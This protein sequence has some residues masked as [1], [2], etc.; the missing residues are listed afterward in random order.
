MDLL[1]ILLSVAVFIFTVAFVEVIYLAW[2]E[3]RFTEKRTVKKRLLYISAGGK[4]GKEKLAKYRASVLKDIGAYERFVLSLPRW[5]RLDS[6]L[7]KMGLPINAS[8]FLI[9]SIALGLTGFLV[10]YRYLPQPL[11]AVILGVALGFL[12]YFLLKVAEKNYY[13]KFIDQLPEALD[14]L[15]RAMRSGHALTSGLEMISK[16]LPDPIKSE[17]MATVDE[18]NLGLTLKEAMENLCE[19]VPLTDLRYF[20][21]AVLVQKETGGNVAEILDNISRLIRERVQFQRQVKA[22][23]AEGRYSAAVLI[24]L[25]ILMFIYIYFTNYDYLSLLWTEELG[26]YLLFGAIILQIVGAYMIKRIVTIEI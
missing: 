22:L 5:S 13:E 12:P 3:S 25:P 11:A 16:E 18:I 7:V 1:D 24:A 2:T 23:T 8:I 19:R 10:G 4:H 17:F 9:F 14:L 20:A 26:P 21:I 15:A 6:L